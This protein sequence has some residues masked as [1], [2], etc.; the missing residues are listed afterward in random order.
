[1]SS[2]PAVPTSVGALLTEEVTMNPYTPLPSFYEMIL[3][4]EAERSSQKILKDA[5]KRLAHKASVYRREIP[6][7]SWLRIRVIRFLHFVEFMIKRYGAEI[8]LI[9]TYFIERRCLLGNACATLAESFYSG[10]RVKVSQGN[11][12]TSMNFQDRIRLACAIAC[13]SYLNEKLEHFFRDNDLHMHDNTNSGAY[14]KYLAFLLYLRPCIRS[15]QSGSLLIYRFLY[16]IG[17]TVYFHPLSHFMQ[18]TVR[19]CTQ[20]D[21]QIDNIESI[22]QSQIHN[23]KENHWILLIIKRIALCGISSTAILGWY[24]QFQEYVEQQKREHLTSNLIPPSPKPLPFRPNPKHRIRIPESNDICPLCRQ[25]WIAPSV[26]TSGFVYCHKCLITYVRE[27]GTCPLTGIACP[28]DRIV[29]IY[30]SEVLAM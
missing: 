8:R 20:E 16:L 27:Y 12:L 21:I 28:E 22:K 13:A 30:G 29:R 3:I 6:S 14:R 11:T 18:A 25:P 15:A 24:H 7:T 19:R 9:I 17:R 2:N 4:E 23:A 1:M 5:L 26:S 10:R